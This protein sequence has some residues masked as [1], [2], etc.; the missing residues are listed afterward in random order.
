MATATPTAGEVACKML[1]NLQDLVSPHRN[2]RK[3]KSKRRSRTPLPDKPTPRQIP[4]TPQEKS[5]LIAEQK[6]VL[7]YE[8]GVQVTTAEHT[9]T[10]L[11]LLIKDD[12]KVG[13]YMCRR[14]SNLRTSWTYMSNIMDEERKA[15]ARQT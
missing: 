9:L 13:K 11:R 6:R 4:K 8:H 3:R 1:T 5:L 14:P 7:Q 12:K 15:A 10:E 2:A